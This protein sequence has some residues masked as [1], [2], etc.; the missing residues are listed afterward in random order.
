MAS[1]R[2][3]KLAIL[4]ELL[5]RIGPG[6]FEQPIAYHRVASVRGHKRLHDQVRN[7]ID[8]VQL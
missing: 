3:V 1:R 6:R 7:A 5:Q 8:D 2:R 4:N